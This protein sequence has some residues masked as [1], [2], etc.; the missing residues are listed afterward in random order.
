MFKQ[1]GYDLMG[2]AFEVFN[3]LGYGMAE[4]I[5][6]QSLE[7]ELNLRGIP[8]QSKHELTPYYKPEF[9]INV[10]QEKRYSPQVV[11][12]KDAKLERIPWI[13]KR[14]FARWMISVGWP[15]LFGSSEC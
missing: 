5:Y 3:Q 1:E 9:G 11:I 6:Q 12:G 13:G 7:I 14:C 10:G 8:F 2:P 15:S 4:E